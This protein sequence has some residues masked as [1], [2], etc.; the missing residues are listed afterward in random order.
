[1]AWFGVERTNAMSD[2]EVD[3]ACVAIAARHRGLV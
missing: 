1:M 3:A 2:D